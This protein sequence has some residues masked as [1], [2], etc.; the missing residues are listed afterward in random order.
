MDCHQFCLWLTWTA[1]LGGAEFLCDLF[2]YLRTA[3]LLCGSDVALLTSLDHDHQCV[4]WQFATNDYLLLHKWSEDG[5]WD[6]WIGAEKGSWVW[7]R[8]FLPVN[9]PKRRRLRLQVAKIDVWVHPQGQGQELG[10]SE[11][12]W[13]RTAAFLHWKVQGSNISSWCLL[14]AF[15]WRYSRHIRLEGDTEADPENAV[16]IIYPT[17]TE[18]ASGSPSRSWRTWLERRTSGMCLGTSA[19]NVD[20]QKTVEIERWIEY[21]I[22]YFP[23]IGTKPTQSLHQ[24]GIKGKM[25]LLSKCY[26]WGSF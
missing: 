1:S 14:D 7:G 2:G 25:W 19:V 23:P 16:G 24:I 13:T 26:C 20:L 5:A 22:G 21:L 15:K 4:L 10:L 18:N 8:D 12:V 11:G 9:L 6:R 3:S 17:Y